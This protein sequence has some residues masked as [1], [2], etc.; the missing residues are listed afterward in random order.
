MR[1]LS[2]NGP[3]SWDVGGGAVGVVFRLAD[4]GDVRVCFVEVVCEE[5]VLRSKS[6]N[7]DLEETCHIIVV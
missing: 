7:D 3:V 6:V 2:G 5:E 4:E 1:V